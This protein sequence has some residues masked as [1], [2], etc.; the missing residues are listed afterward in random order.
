M[1]T[2]DFVSFVKKLKAKSQSGGVLG[3]FAAPAMAPLE[4]P[5]LLDPIEPHHARDWVKNVC[6]ELVKRHKVDDAV[7]RI[8]CR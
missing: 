3:F 1:R 4:M 2:R 6:P 8:L 5:D 7:A